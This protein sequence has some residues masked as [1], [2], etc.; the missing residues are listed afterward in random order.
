MSRILGAAIVAT[1]L[2][3]TPAA[4]KT[5]K[6]CRHLHGHAKKVCVRKHVKAPVQARVPITTT[7]L[8]GSTF[9][10]STGTFA[11]GGTLN[12]FIP[13]K[14]QLNTP[15][16][17]TETRAALTATG[18]G[19]VSLGSSTPYGPAPGVMVLNADGTVLAALHLSLPDCGG[20]TTLLLGGT[21]T[22]PNG[23]NT[24]VLDSVPGPV[25]AHLVVKV[26]LSGKR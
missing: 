5:P 9:T 3:A 13:S 14:V 2:I 26:D 12:G 19:A 7:L 11:I 16:V 10:T 20:D 23:L 22:P 4:A 25:T 18:C 17:V 15:T 6:P 1:A 8:D 21:A 24:L